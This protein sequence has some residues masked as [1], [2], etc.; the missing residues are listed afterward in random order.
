[1]LTNIKDSDSI[2]VLICAAE[3]GYHQVAEVLIKSQGIHVNEQTSSGYNA[4]MVAAELGYHQFVK[5]LLEN[6][7]INLDDRDCY[8]Q[9]ALMKAADRGHREIVIELINRGADIHIKSIDGRDALTWL[10]LYNERADMIKLLIDEGANVNPDVDIPPLILAAHN[11]NL[12]VV[13]VLTESDNIDINIKDYIGNTAL[14]CA[15]KEE[16][17]EVAKFLINSRG[18][19]LNAVSRWGEVL[20]LAADLGDSDIFN[21]L[22]EKGILI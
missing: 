6:K 11:G 1:M 8:G 19:D 7:D 17:R 5:V 15:L 3:K 18:V 14:L 10:S 22:L 21:T 9:T 16:Y 12:D 13:R 20:T 4:L 2:S